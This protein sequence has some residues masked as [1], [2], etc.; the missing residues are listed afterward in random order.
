[1]LDV[2]GDNGNTESP[3]ATIRLL[4]LSPEPTP[5][6]SPSI[7]IGKE[8]QYTIHVATTGENASLF[9]G[10]DGQTLFRWS[11]P[12]TAL[13]NKNIR[14]GTIGFGTAYY[15]VSRI[16]GLRLKLLAGEAKPLAAEQLKP[17]ER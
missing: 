12:L 16:R 9:V 8:H 5:E 15:T 10:R 11:G 7:K 6:Q 13:S 4:G 14:P 1:V 2:R 17:L 3:T